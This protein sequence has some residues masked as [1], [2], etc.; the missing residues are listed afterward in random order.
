VVQTLACLSSQLTKKFSNIDTNPR[1]NAN[2]TDWNYQRGKTSGNVNDGKSKFELGTE[3]SPGNAHEKYASNVD[4]NNWKTSANWNS[5]QDDYGGSSSNGRTRHMSMSCSNGYNSWNNQRDWKTSRNVNDGKSKFDRGTE[6]SPRNAHIKYMSNIDRNN[7]KASAN[8]NSSRDDSGVLSSNG[9][10]RHMSMSCSNDYN[11]WRSSSVG[12]SDWRMSRN[13][14]DWNSKYDHGAAESSGKDRAGAG[15]YSNN[16]ERKTLTNSHNDWKS[17]SRA[18]CY[19][20]CPVRNLLI[21]AI[22]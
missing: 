1:P 5:S 20:T 4:R 12:R 11:S 13:T 18:Q 15:S 8:W 10:T 22:S 17:S 16:Y 14:E 2:A 9:R 3:E 7:W 21:L 6:G 19:K